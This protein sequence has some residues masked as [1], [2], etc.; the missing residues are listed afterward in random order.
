MAC[1]GEWENNID[2]YAVF[3]T[4]DQRND[5]RVDGIKKIPDG[6]ARPASEYPKTYSNSVDEHILDQYFPVFILI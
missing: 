4:S 1:A 6:G 3:E 2:N 5:G